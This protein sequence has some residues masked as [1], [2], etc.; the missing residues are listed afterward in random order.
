MLN[1]YTSDDIS[2]QEDIRT[3]LFCRTCLQQDQHFGKVR[4]AKSARERSVYARRALKINPV[5]LAWSSPSRQF[6]R[7]IQEGTKAPN[8]KTS[9]LI[10]AN[11]KS[12]GTAKNFYSIYLASSSLKFMSGQNKRNIQYISEIY[13]KFPHVLAL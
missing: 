10:D 8:T 2:V 3:G 1:L 6:F 13:A 4:K 11:L 12:I 7:G 5:G 9:L